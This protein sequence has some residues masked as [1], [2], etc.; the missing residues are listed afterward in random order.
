V[1]SFDPELLAA[2]GAADAASPPPLP[3]TAVTLAGL[4]ALAARRARRRAVVAM[5]ALAAL[6]LG[7]VLVHVPAPAAA[8][9]ETAQLVDLRLDLAQLR[10]LLAAGTDTAAAAERRQRDATVRRHRDAAWR[11]ELATAR[12]GIAAIPHQPRE[13]RR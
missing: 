10:R 2:L 4:Q 1:S 13:T 5:C 8:A 3:S 11:C 6:L 7:V 9:G 12:A